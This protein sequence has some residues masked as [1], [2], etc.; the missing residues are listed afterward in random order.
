MEMEIIGTLLAVVAILVMLKARMMAAVN[1]GITVNTN[2]IYHGGGDPAMVYLTAGEAITPGDNIQPAGGTYGCYQSDTGASPSFI[3]TADKNEH[4]TLD[5]NN[6]MTHDYASGEIVG[7]ITGHC[8]V[9][10]IAD[11]NGAT[12]GKVQRIGATDAAECE[13]N[14]STMKYSTGRA[15]TT[16]ASGS[17]F[18]L[19]QWG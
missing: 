11:T 6:V 3:G 4:A 16:A 13:D 1:M 7:I 5:D 18:I 8:H 12:A 2:N 17:A 15:L 9:R 10:K 14:A 19:N